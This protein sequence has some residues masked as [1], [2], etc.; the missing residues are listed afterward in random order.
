M[1]QLPSLSNTND[2][3]QNPPIPTKRTS[4][5]LVMPTMDMSPLDPSSGPRDIG[6]Q[7]PTPPHL[8]PGVLSKD[9]Y[10]RTAIVI[11]TFSFSSYRSFVSYMHLLYYN[12]AMLMCMFMT[13]ICV[14]NVKHTCSSQKPQGFHTRWHKHDLNLLG[15]SSQTKLFIHG[16][17]FTSPLHAFIT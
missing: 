8:S 6:S 16:S 15:L 2:V 17:V 13:F 7:P 10:S 9:C 1:P 4:S 11:I 14:D 3:R 12:N 5:R